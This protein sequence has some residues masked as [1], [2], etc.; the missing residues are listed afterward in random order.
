[1]CQSVYYLY[2]L[3]DHI[4]LSHSNI[5]TTQEDDKN[6]R[7][8]KKKG[9]Y[10][11]N[12]KTIERYKSKRFA[13]TYFDYSQDGLGFWLLYWFD[14]H[15]IPEFLHQKGLDKDTNT[16]IFHWSWQF[17]ILIITIH[18]LH[19]NKILTIHHQHLASLYFHRINKIYIYIYMLS[20]FYFIW[21]IFIWYGV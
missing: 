12:D 15:A 13:S 6:A 8:R 3:C 4:T 18:M 10:I 19:S 16:F 20:P 9:K 21:Y 17:S 5:I 2:K 1:M 14:D 11:D 7:P